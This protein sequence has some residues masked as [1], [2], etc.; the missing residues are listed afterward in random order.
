MS[1]G[2]PNFWD[3]AVVPVDLSPAQL[4]HVFQ[5]HYSSLGR[6][7]NVSAFHPKDMIAWIQ[8]D[9]DV[10]VDTFALLKRAYEEYGSGEAA[11]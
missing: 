6:S 9:L 8:T 1:T 11:D 7:I 2:K 5:A 3:D 10:I 4:M